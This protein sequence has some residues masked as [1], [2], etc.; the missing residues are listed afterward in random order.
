VSSEGGIAFSPQLV[1]C[2]GSTEG[3]VY[4]VVAEMA[5]VEHSY[6]LLIVWCGVAATQHA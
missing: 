1:H 6:A 2:A 5:L 4:Y 3:V